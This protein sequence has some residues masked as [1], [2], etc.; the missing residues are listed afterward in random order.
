[1]EVVQDAESLGAIGLDCDSIKKAFRRFGKHGKGYEFE[2]N[3]ESTM[4][5]VITQLG[6]EMFSTTSIPSYQSIWFR[7]GIGVSCLISLN[8]RNCARKAIVGKFWSVPRLRL[9]TGRERAPVVMQVSHRAKR[10]SRCCSS[11]GSLLAPHHT[12]H[13]HFLPINRPLPVVNL[14]L[15]S[16]LRCRLGEAHQAEAHQ[17]EGIPIRQPNLLVVWAGTTR[18]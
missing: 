7:T 12:G 10:D 8:T 4:S 5:S 11:P 14:P 17:A 13:A 3:E 16:G 1:V 6:I 18:A 9:A 2:C 15:V